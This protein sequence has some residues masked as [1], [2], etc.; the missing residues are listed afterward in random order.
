M[1]LTPDNIVYAQWGWFKLNATLA[2]TWGIMLL[3]TIGSWLATRQLTSESRMSRWQNFLEVIVNTIRQQ[4]REASGQQADHFIGFVG[5]IFLFIAVA[6]LLTIVP[7]YQPPT[8]SLSTTAALA[9]TVF[10]AVP[11]YGITS[12]GIAG[13]LKEYLQPNPIMLP[14]NIISEVSRTLAMAVRLFGNMMSGGLIIAILLSIAPL[15]FPIL[16]QLLGLITGFV[17]AYIFAILSLV[18][19]ASAVRSRKDHHV[20]TQQGG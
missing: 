7:G 15:F 8:A 13:Y 16:L 19:I 2:F 20:Y 4:I 11:I 9:L 3:L 10:I 17:Q 5:S 1:D 18:Y 14:F 12:Q 6:N